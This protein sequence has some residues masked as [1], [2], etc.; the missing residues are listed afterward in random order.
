MLP[1]LAPEK[2]L[3]ARSI[4]LLLVCML[5][6]GPCCARKVPHSGTLPLLLRCAATT[7]EASRL[8]FKLLPLLPLIV[9]M[10]LSLQITGCSLLSK[11]SAV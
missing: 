1:E 8:P 5:C 4:P 6:C 3:L 10:L 2:P 11:W 7:L 9:D